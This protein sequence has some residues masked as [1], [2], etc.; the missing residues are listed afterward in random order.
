M[1]FA[2]CSN[3]Y[4]RGGEERGGG[5]KKSIK[6]MLFPGINLDLAIKVQ[7]LGFYR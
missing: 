1:G 5:P 4:S 3:L 7:V 2:E 6:C